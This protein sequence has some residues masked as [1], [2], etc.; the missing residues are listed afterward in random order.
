[1]KRVVEATGGLVVQTDTF[2]NPVFRNSLARI[3]SAPGSP[4]H[5]ALAS[6][7]TF[8][9]AFHCVLYLTSIDAC[10]VLDAQVL[11]GLEKFVMHHTFMRNPTDSCV[12][13]YTCLKHGMSG[14]LVKL[15]CDQC[16]GA[17]DVALQG[18]TCMYFVDK[19][20][21]MQTPMKQQLFDAVPAIVG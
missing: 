11:L 19:Q 17:R 10:S 2:T 8:E 3:F 13:T 14:S 6:N 20:Y 21:T 5:H 7:A 1:M 9:V 16:G 4:E 18:L 15:G 12:I